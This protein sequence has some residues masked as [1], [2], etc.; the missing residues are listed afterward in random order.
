[1]HRTR[2]IHSRP[3]ILN[4][5]LPKPRLDLKVISENVADKSRN[6]VDRK[7]PLPPGAI[8]DIEQ[9]YASWRRLSGDL[10]QKRHAKTTLGDKIRASGKDAAARQTALDEAKVLKTETATLEALLSNTEDHMMELALGVPNDTHPLSPIGPESAAVTMSTYGPPLLP[11]DPK[12]DHVAI[13]KSLGM[14]DLE[15]GATVTGSSWYYLL[16]EGA[17]LE[18]ALTNYVLSIALRHGFKPV[19][20]PDVVRADIARRCGFNPRDAHADPPVSQM[21]H[22]A[23]SEPELVLSGTA[24]VPLAGLFANRI[25]GLNEVPTKLVG[26]GRAFRAEAGARGADTRGLYRVHQFSKLEMFVTCAGDLAESEKAM[27]EIRAIQTEIFQGLGFTF[28]SVHHI[29]GKSSTHL[30]IQS[31]GHAN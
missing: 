12:R 2:A 29:F 24:E 17:L 31:I 5:E 3:D 22:I 6:A 16:N 26:L 27:E 25:L 28:R 19:L 15:A 13:G 7:A 18:L 30:M 21:Y 1:M 9:L 8:K 20:T 11:A 10:N 14:I 4:S 23:E